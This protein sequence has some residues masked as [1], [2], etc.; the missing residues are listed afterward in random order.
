MDFRSFAI[1]IYKTLYRSGSV[2]A[3]PRNTAGAKRVPKGGVK[4][5]DG[6]AGRGHAETPSMESCSACK[7][8]VEVQRVQA[9]LVFRRRGIL[10]FV[11]A[12]WTLDQAGGDVFDN[13]VYGHREAVRWGPLEVGDIADRARL[14]AVIAQYRPEAVMHFAAYAYIGESVQDPAKYYRNNVAGTLTLLEALVHHGPEP[15]HRPRPFRARGHRSRAR[16][17]RPRNPRDPHRP[18]PRRSAHSYCGRG[19]GTQPAR[20]A[21]AP[22]GSSGDSPSCLELAFQ[23]NAQYDAVDAATMRWEPASI[24]MTRHARPCAFRS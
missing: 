20:V 18:P 14:D 13:L 1:P 22:H 7:V 9:K 21:T 8:S 10:R 5:D 4:V 16:S 24:L 17:N 12:A 11:D 15:W 19:Q 6:R 23:A 3:G 2:T